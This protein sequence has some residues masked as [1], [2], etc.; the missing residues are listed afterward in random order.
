MKR[1]HIAPVMI[2]M[3]LILVVGLS[4]LPAR[5]QTRDPSAPA[6]PV[7]ETASGVLATGKKSV[8]AVGEA[9]SELGD[10]LCSGGRQA[11]DQSRKLWQDVLLPA[12]QRFAAALPGVLKAVILLLAFWLVGK[13]AGAC[14]TRLL[15]LTRIDER[16]VRDWGLESLLKRPTGETCSLASLVGNI[17]KWL[18]VLFGFVAFFNAL[19][20]SM[21]AGPLQNLLDRIIG[22]IPNLIKAVAILLVYWILAAVVRA[23][24]TRA[25]GALKFDERA[26]KHLSLPTTDESQPLGPGAMI[27]RLLFYVIL[28]FGIP[29]FLQAL[30]Q[31]ALVA[32]LQDML[33]KALGILPNLFAAALILVVGRVVTAIVREVV[34]NFLAASGADAAAEKF[35]L[36]R[37]L[38]GNRLSAIAAKVVSFFILIPILISAVDC[39]GI[40]AISDP[41]KAML[42]TILDAVPALLVAAIIVLIG[43][44]VAKVV[45]A[46]VESFLSG[47][48]TD[49]LPGRLGLTFLEAR[50]GQTPPSKLI[51]AITA[52]V[53]L[54]ITAQQ[55][56]AKLRFDQLAE[57]LQRIVAYLPNLAVGLIILLAAMSLGKRFGTMVAGALENHANGKALSVVAHYAVLLLGLSMALEQLGVGKEIVMIAVGS[58][59]GGSALAL[60]LAFGLGGQDRARELIERWKTGK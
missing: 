6:Q 60:G 5:T 54:L 9:T 51:G 44:V 11:V 49:E 37:T 33:S 39:L 59:L 46:L 19:N 52:V 36:S 50:A 7:S 27:G 8:Q 24:V 32:P 40:R 21:V 47:I 16:A 41:L 18:L 14:V 34:T 55:A 2:G 53:I 31:Q 4:A 58:L 20:L 22:V 3:G 38:G 10:S 26:G 23:G 28:L 43:Y 45:R 56:C 25:L 57:L 17:V 15:N 42:Q 1:H 35:G 12:M 48:G 30:D 29:P 13:F